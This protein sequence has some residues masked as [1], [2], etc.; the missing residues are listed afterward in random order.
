MKTL[1]ISDMD[2]TL[3][4]DSMEISPFTR[5]TLNA[6]IGKGVYFTVATARTVD[7]A[8][9]I[10]SGVRLNLP[11]VLSNGAA[12][13]DIAEKKFV[14]IE[15][16]KPGHAVFLFDTLKDAGITG[17]VYTFENREINYY[18]ENL[19]APHRKEFHDDRS[20]KYGRAYIKVNSFSELAN[21]GVFYFST[22]D[23]YEKLAPV[24]QK[25][26]SSGIHVDFYRDIYRPEHHYLE[27]SA[28]NSSKYNGVMFLKEKYGFER[29]ISF[30]DNLNDLPMFEV[31][32]EC[33]ATANA[34]EDVKSRATAVIGA[35]Y[36]DGVAKWLMENVKL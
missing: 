4:N 10:L 17:F 36:N 24:Y 26:L 3:L 19:D 6:L 35:N 29:V 30:G 14:N 20:C 18:Y 25:L 1:Y 27:A 9:Y 7:T 23:S 8:S 16:I 34:K 13:Y 31:S 33:Y 22:A 21:R 2:G 28:A 12:I 32:D 11:V 15:V 5:D